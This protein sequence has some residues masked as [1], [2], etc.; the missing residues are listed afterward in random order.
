[1][2]TADSTIFRDHSIVEFVTGPFYI[3]DASTTLHTVIRMMDAFVAAAFQ[4]QT[5]DCNH[6]TLVDYYDPNMCLI[7][8]ALFMKT[9]C[10]SCGMQVASTLNQKALFYFL[11]LIKKPV[12]RVVDAEAAKIRNTYAVTM[13]QVNFGVPL[14]ILGSDRYRSLVSSWFIPTTARNMYNAIMDYNFVPLTGLSVAENDEWRAIFAVIYWAAAGRADVWDEL[15]SC[16]CSVTGGTSKNAQQL[17]LKTPLN[18]VIRM[19]S[20]AIQQKLHAVWAL[21]LLGDGSKLP[22]T[23]AVDSSVVSDSSDAA[24]IHEY[25]FYALGMTLMPWPKRYGDTCNSGTLSNCVYGTGITADP[26]VHP[27]DDADY[28]GFLSSSPGFRKICQFSKNYAN[29]NHGEYRLRD[30][31]A[32]PD[33]Q[34]ADRPIAPAKIAQEVSVVVEVRYALTPTFNLDL[35]ANLGET[36]PRFHFEQD[37]D[38]LAALAALHKLYE[39]DEESLKTRS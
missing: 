14:R 21:I 4:Q 23:T 29:A 15:L 10:G 1:L 32:G 17:L 6:P 38:A 3:K 37:G 30:F 19:L 9:Y 5:V 26:V 2:L 11:Q 27:C 25:V 18:L 8:F 28:A 20:P 16:T 13:S 34:F 36:P 33:V 7:D 39:D 22:F 12:L 31:G 35:R 24:H